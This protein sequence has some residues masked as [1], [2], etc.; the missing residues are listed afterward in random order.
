MNKLE[1]ICGYNNLNQHDLDT[2]KR[3]LDVL[4]K[5]ADPDSELYINAEFTSHGI[6]M[7]YD[8]PIGGILIS[9]I[10]P[11][12]NPKF[13]NG[14]FYTFSETMQREELYRPSSYWRNKEKQLYDKDYS[15]LDKTAYIDLFPYAQSKQK[16]F[17]TDIKNNIPFQVRSLEITLDEIERL[18]PKLV[19]A[20]NKTTSYYWGIADD[21]TWLGYNLQKVEKEEKPQCLLNT[22]LRLYRIAGKT[23]YKD[24]NDRIGQNKFI[25]KSNLLGAYFIEYGLYDERMNKYPQSLL[26]PKLLKALYNHIINEANK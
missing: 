3:Y 1:D 20:A 15:L 2:A 23:G 8:N 21:A 5:A 9:G 26:T 16:Q 22:K 13:P 25:Q 17:I 11:G 19:I 6:S 7:C 4:N 18:K 14:V 10:N 12:Y 24:K